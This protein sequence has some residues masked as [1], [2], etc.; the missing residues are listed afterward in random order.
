MTEGYKTQILNY[1]TNNVS[2]TQKSV[3][4]FR[5]NN[6]VDNN[7]TTKL[8]ELGISP[9]RFYTLTTNTTSNYLIYGNYTNDDINYGFIVV[10]SQNND[11]LH[12]FTNYDSGTNI[13]PITRLEYNE[14]GT[15]Y[16]ID[17][18]NNR[19]R[20]ILL[21]NIALNS[22]T[23]YH[24]NL[25]KSYY[26]PNQNY[27]EPSNSI[28]GTSIIKKVPEESTYFIFGQNSSTNKS[29]LI[30]FTIN[31]G[32]E[33][34]W[35]YY[36]GSSVQTIRFSD[37]IFEKENENTNVYIGYNDMQN[38]TALVYEYFN[39]TTLSLIKSYTT[40]NSTPILDIR[41]LNE[42]NIYISSRD[43]LGDGTYQM[44]LYLLQDEVFNEISDFNINVQIPTYYLNLIGNVIFGRAYGYNLDDGQRFFSICTA[45][46]GKEFV[47]SST[48]EIQQN[49]YLQTGCAVQN[50]FALYKFI[51][52]GSNSVQQP[53]IVIYQN[54]YS[55][56]SYSDYDSL[57]P[58]KG[59]L[60]SNNIIV[61]ARPLYDKTYY[62][63][64]TVSTLQVPNTYLNDIS[65]NPNRLLS[66]TNIPISNGNTA[67]IK[68][69][70]ELLYINFINTLSVTDGDNSTYY[71]KSAI[72]INNNINNGNKQN[73]E[74]SYIGKVRINYSTPQI[75]NINWVWNTDHYETS[76]TIYTNEIP[77][78]IDFISNDET[79]IY[80]TKE[81][82]LQQNKYYTISQKLRI[83]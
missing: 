51:I 7:L 59:E 23:G 76:F 16:G 66:K 32:A 22:S 18:T 57:I 68:N 35:D 65:L 62:S 42:N 36:Y 60:Y 69:I 61:Y 50:N 49:S 31:V 52:Q 71:P 79:T 29:M 83:E 30:K 64:V 56:G 21:N 25:R 19:K 75:Q 20:V 14:D 9:T 77:T 15:I 37:F 41:I 28:A 11:I 33:N 40:P 17:T 4:T 58:N 45:Y 54:L 6:I 53:S 80:I 13:S 73:C 74:S 10:L 43:N 48:Y 8:N 24:C 2:I 3:N 1:I 63:N 46:D 34:E 70:Y 67:I 44:Y 72:Y 26:I 81:V 78:S 47:E 39:G 82:N 12:I 27:Q 38:G 55:G 5:D